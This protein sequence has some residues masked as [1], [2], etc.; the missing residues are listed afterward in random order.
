MSRIASAV[1]GAL[2]I[3]GILIGVPVALWWLGTPLLLQIG[4]F[5]GSPSDLILRPDDGT[6]LM[7]FLAVV[8]TV[9]W[10]ILAVSLVGEL[11][12][13]LAHRPP[14]RITMPGFRLGG[15]VAGALVAMLLGTGPALAA[16]AAVT[17]TLALI[18]PLKPMSVVDGTLADGPVHVVAPRDT[19]WRIAETAL[20]DP[21][22]WREIYELNAGHVQADGG[23]LTEGSVL[24]V[25]WQLVMPA[26]AA[27]VIR[28]GPGDT[29]TGLAAEYLGD[30]ARA[31]DLFAA[32][33]GST[34]PGGARL[35]DP[36][37]LRPGWTLTLH[38]LGPAPGGAPSSSVPDTAHP[39]A[40]SA[41]P[42]PTRP[43]ATNPPVAGSVPTA[44]PQHPPQ[45]EP[46][47]TPDDDQSF[48]AMPVIA[49]A[50]ISTL[51]AA[52]VI[53][54]LAIRR[55][56]Q[57]RYRPARHRI[58]VPSDDSAGRLEWSA[59]TAPPAAHALGL[60]LAL[61]SLAHPGRDRSVTPALR[62][63]RV[64]SSGA[65][66]TLA[67]PTSAPDPFTE[68]GELEWNLDPAATLP[69]PEGEAAG[70]CSP[71]PALVTVATADDDDR[72]L[73]LEL[74]E[75]GVLS[76]GG[77]RLR[78]IALL[79]H[80]AAE[81]ATN[82][83]AEDA[84]IILVGL[85]DE[86]ITLNPEQMLQAPDLSAALTKIEN[87]A[88]ATRSELG[89]HQMASAVEGRLR[90]VA[91]DSWLPT[92]VLSAAEPTEQERA[93]LRN[94]VTTGAGSAA[95][96]VVVFDPEETR[97]CVLPDG[98][99]ELP[100][101]D[102]GPWW[103]VQ[104]TENAGT[105]L[106]SLLGS[107]DEPAVPV[108]PADGS[109]AWADGMDED[110]ALTDDL[111]AVENGDDPDDDV[112]GGPSSPNSGLSDV[113]PLTRSSADPEA[114]RRLAMVEHQDPRLDDDLAAWH[115][116]NT[117]VQP[118]IAILGE[119]TV[120]A[121]GPPPTAR[122]SWFAEVLVYLSLHPAGVTAAKAVTDLWPDG[123]R[124]SPSTIRHAFYG[125]RRWAGRGLGGDPGATFVS[126]M[127]NDSTYRLRGHLSDWDLFRR[128]RKRGQARHGAG[129]SD[130]LDDYEAALALIRGPV[131]SALR[132]GGYAWLNNHDQRHDLQI[133][134]FIVD[135]AHELVDI[136]LA[137]GDTALARHAAE[138]A[139]FVDIDV[140]F[141][142]P[143]TDLMRVAHAEDNRAELELHASVLLDA[144]GFEVP[145]ELA[146]DSFAVL[147][148][149][150][151]T[152]PAR[153]ARS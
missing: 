81:L 35:D 12:A 34:Q 122:P 83:T 125:A 148:E 140:A 45:A 20:G 121:P 105:H 94:L 69:V 16:P 117:P 25:G 71:F 100:D 59:A 82:R 63:V 103:A 14:P 124:I 129:R 115:D 114:L 39:P 145:E 26:D 2:A 90:D 78:V 60:D 110:G 79:R 28:V 38:G 149:L 139:R 116:G 56:R 44:A 72:R 70:C 48:E 46:A 144:R 21:L 32:N 76:I 130:G 126:D 67:S 68:A 3:A 138:Q 135:T 111:P 98:V 88:E 96:C 151:P 118:M 40:A 92:V 104:L 37:Q 146:P 10:L 153:T 75:R 66:L 141:D 77:D 19:L 31:D 93:R 84:E 134:G 123:H 13:A 6:L 128:L 150:L 36:D 132:P 106:A 57:L 80:L 97:T 47:P 1:T 42:T 131:L 55:R 152:G 74:E 109:E 53:A 54:A 85:D 99:L 61:R 33:S 17:A 29:L 102:D 147:N 15:L 87:R 58:S 51:I 113:V 62:L 91:A 108:G 11:L 65:R 18:Q 22:R 107:T 101:G 112:E 24:T 8:A 120:R 43:P 142:Q 119:P 41:T 143:L 127:Q 9:V 73:L 50:G 5:A 137:A 133:P 86:L 89:R 95:V 64:A 23:R 49:A 136:A 27:D 4:S 52:G 7:G 30:P